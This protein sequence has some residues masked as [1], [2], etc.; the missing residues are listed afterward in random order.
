MGALRHCSHNII[1]II[2]IIII[3]PKMFD[4]HE[5]D[6]LNHIYGLHVSWEGLV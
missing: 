6:L 1:I 4:V 3:V 5:Y 2:I